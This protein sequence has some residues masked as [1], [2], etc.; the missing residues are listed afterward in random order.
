[1][2]C[3]ACNKERN[4]K[5]IVYTKD[6]LPY[7]SN[8]FTCGDN[9]PN[10]TKN[11][12]TRQSDIKMYTESEL[13]TVLFEVLNVPEEIKERVKK[14]ASKPQSIRLNKNDVAYYLTMLQ[15][16]KG[17]SSLS[18]AVRYCVTLASE[19]EPIKGVFPPQANFVA[20]NFEEKPKALRLGEDTIEIPLVPSSVN[21]DW[22]NLEAEPEATEEDELVF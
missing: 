13:D 18:E 6:K 19:T 3:S 20:S 1:M 15:E 5:E 22:D 2:K 16:T 14:I 11:I 12:L 4:K 21:V 10:S 17:F 9:H 7:C 8:P